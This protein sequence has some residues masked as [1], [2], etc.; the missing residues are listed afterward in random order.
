MSKAELNETSPSLPLLFFSSP[1]SLYHPKTICNQ[2]TL[3][4]SY[5]TILL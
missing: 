3:S 5:A 1:S 4:I 2:Q